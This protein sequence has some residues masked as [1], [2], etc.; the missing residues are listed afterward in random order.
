M[1]K[2]ES[3]II[4]LIEKKEESYLVLYPFRVVQLLNWG[5]ILTH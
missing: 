1:L 2:S 4:F 3:K 5:Y